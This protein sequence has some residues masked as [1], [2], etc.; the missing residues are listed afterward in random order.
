MCTFVNSPLVPGRGPFSDFHSIHLLHG[1][2]SGQPFLC[3]LQ[4]SEERYQIGMVATVYGVAVS[5][6]GVVVKHRETFVETGSS[7]VERDCHSLDLLMI[8]LKVVELRLLTYVVPLHS[9][10]VEYIDVILQLMPVNLQQCRNSMWEY[11][12]MEVYTVENYCVQFYGP[13]ACVRK[14]CITHSYR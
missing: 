12:T 5:G 8:L 6:R 9:L 11:T 13:I 10:Q 4:S 2:H 1:Q 14:N 7:P 3:E